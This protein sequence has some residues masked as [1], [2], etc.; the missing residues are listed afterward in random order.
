MYPNKV[1]RYDKIDKFFNMPDP[2]GPERRAVQSVSRGSA[3]L[4]T[5]D[6]G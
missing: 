3:L 2:R 6:L 5:A 4:S 1:T